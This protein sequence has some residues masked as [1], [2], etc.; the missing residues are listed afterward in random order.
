MVAPEFSWLAPRRLLVRRAAIA[1]LGAEAFGPELHPMLAA[2]AVSAA[3]RERLGSTVGASH[4]AARA[5]LQGALGEV[6]A[7]YCEQQLPALLERG[8]TLLSAGLREDPAATLKR[9][10]GAF[11]LGSWADSASG[12]TTALLLLGAQLE[13]PALDE[14]GYLIDSRVIAPRAR[15]AAYRANLER[16]LAG[17]VPVADLALTLPA[18]LRAPAESSPGSLDGQIGFVLD[19]WSPYLSNGLL[20]GLLRV[21]DLTREEV[22]R[23]FGP[24]PSEGPGHATPEGAGEATPVFGGAPGGVEAPSESFSEDRPW[25]AECVL[26]AKQTRVWLDQLGRAR[27]EE[28]TRLDQI[29]DDELAKLAGR[30]FTGLWL[31]G[32]WERSVASRDIKRRMGNPEAE[33]S[34]YSLK[35]YRIAAELGGDEAWETLRDR[36]KAHGIRLAADM[37]PNHVGLD[38]DWVAEHPDWFVQTES[39]PYPNYTFRGPNLSGD[40]RVEIRIEDGYWDRSDAAV[41]FERTDPATGQRRYLYHGNDGTQMPWNDTAQIDF[42]HAEA[43]QAVSDTILEVARRFPIIRFDAA[44]TLARQHVQ[45]LWHPKPGDGGAIASRSRYALSPDEF[46]AA[47]PNEFWREVVERVRD[48]A[49]DTLLLAEAFWMLEGYFVRSLGM[50]RVYNSA[51]MHMLRDEDN[52][53][54]RRAIRET[55]AYSPDVLERYVNFLNNPDEETAVEQF[56]KSDKYFGICTLL[57]TLPGTPM[58]G[59]GQVEGFAEKYGMEYRRAYRDEVEDAGFVA[60]HEQVIFP[61]LRRRH[62]FAG[63]EAFA[64]Y[65]FVE[66]GAT[67]EDV[68]AYSN[69]SGGERSLVL[70]N[71]AHSAVAGT[72]RVAVPHNVGTAEEPELATG[73]LTT[74]LQLRDDADVFY[75]FRELRDGLWYLRSGAELARAGLR[76][77]LA[78]YG[79]AV[80]LDF[81]EYVDHDGRWARL[82]QHFGDS[83]VLDLAAAQR[84]LEPAPQPVPGRGPAV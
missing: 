3:L 26:V 1:E 7:V 82:R 74:A 46:D 35:G 84:D 30:G 24:G 73:T 14:S 60:W 40:D 78:G 79:C 37:V 64:L 59:H 72:L 77:S 20:D 25:M 32:I 28:I 21:R 43:R 71:N 58:F 39:P 12:Q 13:N 61:L 31:I 51:F 5:A 19:H 4:I 70:Y 76:W 68:F 53:G 54:Y 6:A 65:D 34:A 18:L 67:H 66:D 83:G 38:A 63:C 62:L 47:M 36:A 45:R 29:P 41:V 27:G 80:L 69:R 10:A 23:Y 2:E 9:L 42:L 49:P 16:W 22:P 75:G 50:H 57:A 15:A 17:Q 33:A 8:A 48:E 52:A 56:G 55:L 11:R 44:M 81:T